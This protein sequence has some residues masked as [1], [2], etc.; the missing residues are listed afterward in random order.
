MLELLREDYLDIH[1]ILEPNLNRRSRSLFCYCVSGKP[2]QSSRSRRSLKASS[3]HLKET[4]G[5]KETTAHR[6]SPDHRPGN[7]PRWVLVPGALLET[8]SLCGGDDYLA[9]LQRLLA[10]VQSRAHRVAVLRTDPDQ[11]PHGLDHSWGRRHSRSEGVEPTGLL[12]VRAVPEEMCSCFRASS[13]LR[14]SRQ[15]SL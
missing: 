6:D 9:V 10:A 2:D 11:V 5:W 3:G 14:I 12:R 1:S 8:G 7:R 4:A 15:R 13:P